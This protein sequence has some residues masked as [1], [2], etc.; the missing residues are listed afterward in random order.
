[1][2]ALILNL[3]TDNNYIVITN[4]QEITMN[5]W[6]VYAIAY[7]SYLVKNGESSQFPRWFPYILMAVILNYELNK[8]HRSLSMYLLSSS[9]SQ[10]WV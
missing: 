8:N 9:P 1:M 5:V 6:S 10:I 7:I 2:L 4:A 3:T